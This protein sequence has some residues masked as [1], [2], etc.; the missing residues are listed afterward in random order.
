MRDSDW[1]ILAVL[2]ETKNI[3]QTANKLFLAQPT[4]TRRLQQ[5]ESELGAVLVLRSNKGISFTPAGEYAAK[6]AASMVQLFQDVR[7]SISEFS[8]TNSGLLRIGAPKSYVQFVI[9]QVL[10]GFCALF[11]HIKIDIHT[12]LSHELLHSVES[13]QL[14]FAFVRGNIHTVL[15]KELLSEDP[16]YALAKIPL[17]LDVISHMPRIEYAKEQTVVKATEQWWNERFRHAPDIRFLVY[18]GDACLRMVQHNLGYGIF[19]D[20]HYHQA[21]PELFA[22]PLHFKDGTQFTRASWMV[23]DKQNLPHNHLLSKFVEFT[24]KNKAL[25][26]K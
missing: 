24:N 9:P 4:L 23:Y 6:K 13:S 22:M 18:S 26:L 15:Q 5:I 1:Q 7:Q 21:D 3:T 2:H 20:R 25:I 10:E 19:S 12:D 14:D 8:D 17:T 11:P 16:I